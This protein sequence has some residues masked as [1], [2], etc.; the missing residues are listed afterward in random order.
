M[1]PGTDPN[2][3]RDLEAPT[4]C[5]PSGYL[6]LSP[7]GSNTR[8]ERQTAMALKKQVSSPWEKISCS[9][10]GGTASTA[11]AMWICCVCDFFLAFPPVFRVLGLNAGFCTCILVFK[12]ER[13]FL[14]QAPPS[15][16]TSPTF[17]GY[18]AMGNPPVSQ[19]LS[20]S[21]PLLFTKNSAKA[22][23]EHLHRYFQ[24]RVAKSRSVPPPDVSSNA[25]I[26]SPRSAKCGLSS[27]SASVACAL[28]LSFLSRLP[29]PL[30]GPR[31]VAALANF[32]PFSTCSSLLTCP[33]GIYTLIHIL[34]VGTRPVLIF[35]Y[36]FVPRRVFDEVG[37]WGVVHKH[38][39]STILPNTLSECG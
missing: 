2:Q 19:T 26:L 39:T 37:R 30:S 4:R 12:Q 14:S 29:I 33:T 18:H 22:L 6:L 10:F 38:A 28:P 15:S 24:Y 21:V 13:L 16:S 31:I 3:H 17:V 27:W 32:P 34:S 1:L 8:H 35:K 25:P 7:A 20:G 5:F 36:I 23:L 9:T 11:L